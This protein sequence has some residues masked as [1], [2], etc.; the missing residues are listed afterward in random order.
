MSTLVSAFGEQVMR[1][2]KRCILVIIFLILA[3][4]LG[5][6]A[7]I[8]M[9]IGL[10]GIGALAL[11]LIDLRWSLVM[12]PAIALLV[13]LEFNTGTQVSLNSVVF[14]LPVIAVLWLVREA[15]S[16]EVR[17]VNSRL[18]RPLIAFMLIAVFSLLKGNVTW[19]SAVPR[20]SDLLLVQLAQVSIYALSFLSFWSMANMITDLKWLRR[21]AYDV[22]IISALGVAIL[23]L[24]L[25]APIFRKFLLRGTLPNL[26][27]VWLVSLCLAFILEDHQLDAWQR[28]AMLLMTF[29][30]LTWW[31]FF[32]RAW[33]GAWIPQLLAIGTI[34]WWHSPRSRIV[35][36]T[37]AGLA[38]L[39]LGFSNVLRAI[40]WE[41]EWKSS[42]TARFA[43]WQSVINLGAQSPILGLGPVAYRHY[44]HWKPL[45]L[46]EI[47][48]SHPNVSAHNLFVD[49]FAQVGLLGLGCYLWFL[50]E[51]IVLA[52]RL[53][54]QSLGFTKGYALAIL[55]GIMG[56]VV[57]DIVAA[58]SLPFVYNV[59]FWGF[60]G[61]IL[62]WMLLGGLVVI[63]NFDPGTA[64]SDSL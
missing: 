5:Q 21:I 49:L 19:D 40:D 2:W 64:D 33:L 50:I 18:N 45:V 4:A 13:P 51:S 23:F 9:F 32:Q 58:T 28:L 36:I 44:H 37:V 20:P 25:L 57:A 15:H 56:G 34:L 27:T 55:G 62:G 41:A 10:L 39:T 7:S 30:S 8:L 24:S 35:L 11:V 22:V 48:W 61:S 16:H 63:E 54:R 52:S 6:R 26:A 46:R 1:H 53:Y 17:L 47:Y 59:G 42:V 38:V 43:L 12:L 3:A 29:G 31:W 60:R 14:V